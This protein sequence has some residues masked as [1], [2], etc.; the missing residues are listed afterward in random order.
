EAYTLFA[1]GQTAVAVM[2]ETGLR[3]VVAK[4][5][6]MEFWAHGSRAGVEATQAQ[7]ARQGREPEMPT[8]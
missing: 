7:Q 3:G 2:G 8:P 6:L 4:S 1:G 5:D